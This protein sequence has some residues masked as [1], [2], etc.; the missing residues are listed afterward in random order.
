M[1]V[2]AG[3]IDRQHE[4]YKDMRVGCFHRQHFVCR[5]SAN[6]PRWLQKVDIYT[7]WLRLQASWSKIPVHL[8]VVAATRDIGEINPGGDL[9]AEDAVNVF[10]KAPTNHPLFGVLLLAEDVAGLPRTQ[11]IECFMPPHQLEAKCSI[12]LTST[13]DDFPCCNEAIATGYDRVPDACVPVVDERG[14]RIA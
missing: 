14:E 9:L 10:P 8:S 3:R 6:V 5:F 11:L 7:R 1:A 2:S 13:K 12:V 4:A